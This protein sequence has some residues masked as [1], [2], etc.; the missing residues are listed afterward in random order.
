MGDVLSMAE[1][2]DAA[3]KNGKSAANPRLLD[4]AATPEK[5]RS[6]PFAIACPCPTRT[7]TRETGMSLAN[8]VKPMF[9]NAIPISPACLE[10]GE[11]MTLFVEIA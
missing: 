9:G 7:M 10:V 8:L 5:L 6:I 3:V 11:A 2:V 4:P 1:Q